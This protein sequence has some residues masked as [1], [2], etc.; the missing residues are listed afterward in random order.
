MVGLIIIILSFL[1]PTN[2]DIEMPVEFQL[3]KNHYSTIN[4]KISNKIEVEWSNRNDIKKKIESTDTK[5]SAISE[6]YHYELTHYV[7]N[8]YSI[9]P[10]LKGYIHGHT[11]LKDIYN[12]LKSSIN[13][14]GNKSKCWPKYITDASN[15]VK[16]KSKNKTL[17]NKKIQPDK[18]IKYKKHSGKGAVNNIINEDEVINVR[19]MKLILKNVANIITSKM[20]IYIIKKKVKL[21]IKKINGIHI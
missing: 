18:K 6:K 12:F 1:V 7:E 20:I 11:R 13:Y 10:Q 21:K 17:E 19:N 4:S 15:E 16:N 8:K 2:T 14:K 3:S 5:T 9:Y